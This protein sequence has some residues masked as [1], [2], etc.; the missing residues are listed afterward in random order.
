MGPTAGLDLAE[1]RKKL[2]LDSSVVQPVT[3]SPTA[4]ANM[5]ASNIKTEIT[6]IGFRGGTKF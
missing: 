6:E 2:S 1:E 5:W 3:Y 4:R